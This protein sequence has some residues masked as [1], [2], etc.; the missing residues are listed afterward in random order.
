MNS[1]PIVTGGIALAL[2]AAFVLQTL[3]PSLV[4]KYALVGNLVEDEPIRIVTGAFLHGDLPHFITNVATLL[5][6]GSSVE[7]GLGKISTLLVYAAALFGG[8]AAV[9]FWED[10]SVMTVGASGAIYG[11]FGAALLVNLVTLSWG[12]LFS[13]IAVIGINAGV[14]FALPGISWQAHMGG[15]AAGFV[16]AVPCVIVV[17]LLGRRRARKEQEAADRA[18]YYPGYQQL[19]DRY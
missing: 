6:L 1:R 13:S 4:D 18:G 7:A 10:P 12:P 14:S 15:L 16:V 3:D 11:L 19:P 5:V 2:L 8:Q 9:L 17:V